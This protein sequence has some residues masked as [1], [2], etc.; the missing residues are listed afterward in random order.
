[1][2]RQS[3]PGS[4]LPTSG[5]WT[6][7]PR[8]TTSS[9]TLASCKALPRCGSGLSKNSARPCTTRVSPSSGS[10]AAGIV[11]RSEPPTASSSSSPGPDR[12][13]LP[14][15]DELQCYVELFAFQQRDH[16]LQLVLLLGRDPQ[17][18]AL[19]LGPDALGAF[20][21][22]DLGDLPGVVLGDSLLQAD[23]DLV[24]LA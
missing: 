1:M 11:S 13:W 9:P 12:L 24:L 4:R 17:L 19:H 20:V 5:T 2:A 18:F 21:P 23:A 14:V 15:V 8:S 6:S 22:D 16:V 10:T 7:T 3:P